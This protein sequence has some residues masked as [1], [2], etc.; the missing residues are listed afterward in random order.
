MFSLGVIAPASEFLW[1]H[2]HRYPRIF[3]FH[4]KKFGLRLVPLGSFRD[5][6]SYYLAL[7]GVHGK[8]RSREHSDAMQKFVLVLLHFM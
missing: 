2:L 1:R 8:R 7:H 4:T 5:V 3:R 6:F